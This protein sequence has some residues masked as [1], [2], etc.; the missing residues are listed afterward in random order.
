LELGSVIALDPFGSS[1]FSSL[2]K[3]LQ[4]QFLHPNKIVLFITA[5]VMTEKH[6]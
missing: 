3:I 5:I 4:F 1:S 6:I 2:L